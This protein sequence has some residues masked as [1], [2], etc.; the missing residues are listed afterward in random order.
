[1]RFKKAQIA[2]FY[3][4]SLK[5]HEAFYFKKQELIRKGKKFTEGF[6]KKTRCIYL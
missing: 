4:L 6:G 3:P 5:N 2:C 1:M